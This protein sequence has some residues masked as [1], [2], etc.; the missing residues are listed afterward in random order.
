MG[1]VRW[2]AGLRRKLTHQFLSSRFSDIDKVPMRTPASPQS[3][4]W[5]ADLGAPRQEGAGGVRLTPHRVNISWF[6]LS[7]TP[8]SVSSS[9]ASI[10][11]HRA[12]L[13]QSQ[14]RISSLVLPPPKCGAD[15]A[16]GSDF[17]VLPIFSSK[18][19]ESFPAL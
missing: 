15:G 8:V 5:A 4:M 6:E 16:P 14:F 7:T 3:I 18:L 19:S 13:A 9:D 12:I 2:Q 1:C 11:V 10:P 17:D